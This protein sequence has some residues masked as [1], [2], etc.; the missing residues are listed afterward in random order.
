MLINSE[1]ATFLSEDTGMDKPRL[2]V[3]GAQSSSG[4]T[5]VTLGLAGLLMKIGYRVQTFKVGPDYI[6]PSYHAGSTKRP[7]RNLDSWMVPPA[8]ILEI[9]KHGMEEADIALVEGVMG[10]YDGV[11]GSGEA[12]STAEIAKKLE[13]PVIL[14]VDV[15][16]M[17]R[18]AGALVLGYKSFDPQVNLQGVV[19]NRISTPSHARWC[20]EAI[21]KMAKIPVVGAIPKSEKVE[22]PERHLGL[23]P[24]KER[25]SLEDYF[26]KIASHMEAHV[27]L[28]RILDIAAS[29]QKLQEVRMSLFPRSPLPKKVRIG[30]ALDE[31]FNFYYQENLDLLSLHGA[32]VVPFSPIHDRELPRVDGLYLGGG[33]PEVLPRDLEANRNMR[34]QIK[35]AAEDHMPVYAECGG[36]MYLTKSITDFNGRSY[37]MAGVFSGKTVMTRRL[38]LNYTLAKVRKNHLL[39]DSNTKL[40]GHEF[41]YSKIVEVPS[42][43]VFAYDMEKG[44]GI[45]GK[46]DAW[47]L[48]NTFASYMHVHFACSL[49]PVRNFIAY[50]QKYRKR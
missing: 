8:R 2:V 50:C 15:H 41:H 32:K 4:K 17:A 29:S 26:S 43:A 48:Y 27:D 18:T 19:L 23:I 49:K 1:R 21:E 11:H 45:D 30:I 31:A 24:V 40:R 16:S 47:V 34:R 33:F 42:D 9:F 37:R 6:D 36:L 38:C 35:K 25:I 10:L 12:G 44:Y 7:C 39:A 13:A 3:A 14:V 46:H 20:K 28:A 5:T 22:M